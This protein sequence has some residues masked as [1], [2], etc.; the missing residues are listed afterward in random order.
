MAKII[1]D[2]I[3]GKNK[4]AT[5]NKMTLSLVVGG[6]ALLIITFVVFFFFYQ[7]SQA[8]SESGQAFDYEKSGNIKLGEYKGIEASIVVTDGDIESEKEFLLEDNVAV[9]KLEG[10]V[11]DGD[12]VNIDFDGKVNGSS[13]EG[14]TE[15][16]YDL[17]IGS[18]SFIDGFEEQLV[19]V[20]TG[21][22][23]DVKATFPKDYGDE[24]VDGKEAVFTVKVNYI[25]GDEL[26]NT[27]NDEF[28]Q[29][30]SDG[31]Y[32]TVEEYEQYIKQ[33]LYE[34]NK[35]YLP[36]TIWQELAGSTKV[37]KYPKK[38]TAEA[39]NQTKMMYEN[40]EEISGSTV[41]DLGMSEEDISSIAYDTVTDRMIAKTIAAKEGITIDDAYMRTALMDEMEYTEEDG[42]TLE[43]LITEYEEGYSSN[44]YNDMLVKK[45]KE[46]VASHANVTE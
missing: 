13:F 34:D 3:T 38:E 46:F 17:E 28:V 16:G 2:S 10:T 21:E 31:E 41:E 22:T 18:D 9:E 26:E 40:F 45:V 8:L 39:M 30:I 27:F 33:Y 6:V 36:E 15:E 23:V 20:K 35:E 19:G 24:E 42:K 14:G 29:T 43:D 44:P 5:N 32:K 4:K 1:K 7:S 25:H 37:K 12:T 11:K